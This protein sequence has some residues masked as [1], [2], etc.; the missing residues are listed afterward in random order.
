MA[1]YGDGDSTPMGFGASACHHYR[2]KNTVFQYAIRATDVGGCWSKTFGTVYIAPDLNARFALSGSPLCDTSP[3]IFVNYSEV[4]PTNLSWFKWYFGDG[5]TYTSSSP[6]TYSESVGANSKWTGFIH[7]YVRGGVFDPILVM[8]HKYYN[9][10]DS[11]VYSSL[12]LPLPENILIK[13]D[14]RSRRNNSNDTIAD[15]VCNDNLN[16]AGLCLY[17]NYPLQGINTQVGILWDFADPNANP[18]QSDKFL[19]QPAPCYRYRGMGQYF[20]TLTVSCPGKPV[21]VINFWSRIDTIND[22]KNYAAPPWHFTNYPLL[23]N[24][25]WPL[26]P[27]YPRINTINGY[28]FNFADEIPQFRLLY[29]NSDVGDTIISVDTVAGVEAFTAPAHGLLAGDWIKFSSTGSVQGINNYF[30]YIVGSVT[31]NSFSLSDSLNPKVKVNISLGNLNPPAFVPPIYQKVIQIPFDSIVSYWKWFNNDS[32]RF[33]YFKKRQDLYGYGVN[34]LGPKVQV[35]DPLA[36]PPVVILPFLRT[37]CGPDLPVEFTNATNLYQSNNLYIKWD[38]ADDYAPRCTSFSLPDPSK[39]RGIIAPGV[40]SCEGCEPYTSANDMINRTVGRFIVDGKIYPGR[41]NC[42]FSHDTLPL[43]TFEP[44]DKIL[45]WYK[46]GHDFPPY[47]ASAN[48]WTT[49]PAEANWPNGPGTYPS[50]KKLVAPID[51]AKW[52]LPVFSAGP[53][54]WRIDTMSRIWPADIEPNRI[55]TLN[56]TIPDPMANSKGYWQYNIGPGHRIDTSGFIALNDLGKLPNGALRRYR[57]NTPIGDGTTMYDYF[58]KRGVER[59]YTVRLTM[60]DSFNNQSADPF[61][62]LTRINMVNGKIIIQQLTD[63]FPGQ[64]VIHQSDTFSYTST[65]PSIVNDTLIYNYKPYR[66]YTDPSNNQKYILKRDDEFFVDYFDC[67]KTATIQLAL[68]GVDAYGLGS[69]GKICPGLFNGV[70]GGNPR[71]AF[72]NSTGSPGLYPP[73]ATRT[74]LLINYD[75]LLDR[76]DST[77]CA[78]DGFVGWNGISPMTNTNITPGGNIF[79]GFFN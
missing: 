54:P 19:N 36:V 79:P 6:P 49:N 33:N 48:G 69:A 34:I 40:F 57:G 35:E 10:V 47:D 43:H 53:T 44:W 56:T 46:Y 38:F 14:L 73:C 20:P 25:P 67:G 28:Q 9:C 8:K 29:H 17:N 76:R 50:G 51:A 21:K 78:L 42:N 74:W 5:S 45:T 61:K 58:F 70:S 55:I 30:T 62:G 39:P 1:T 15:S 3:Y 16:T 7:Q 22:T 59:C 37:Q 27:L 52:G 12:N 31:A 75:S 68:V 24:P 64:S 13:Y 2:K 60:K 32:T 65:P 11:F 23:P 77:P 4:S 63:P 71:I 72:D 26:N 18:P 41:V 66:V